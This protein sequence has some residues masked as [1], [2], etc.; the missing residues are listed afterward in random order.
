MKDF[1]REKIDFL[2]I[3]QTLNKKNSV[4]FSEKQCI[5]RSFA[6]F[7]LMLLLSAVWSKVKE[8]YL[9]TFMV[10]PSHSALHQCPEVHAVYILYFVKPFLLMEFNTF[11]S[12][13]CN[14]SHSYKDLIE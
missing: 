4:R 6:Q 12:V 3:S 11:F 14:E 10:T 2:F 8:I 7:Y 5:S 13:G 1:S 9:S